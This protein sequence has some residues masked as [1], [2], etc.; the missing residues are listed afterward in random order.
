MNNTFN[1][2]NQAWLLIFLVFS[3]LHLTIVILNHAYFRTFAYDYGVYNFAFF[4]FAHL[5][6]SSCP[7]YHNLYTVSFMQD[8]FSLTLPML[9]PLYWLFGWLAGSY[10]LLIIQW[11]FITAGAFY[12]H[13]YIRLKSQN[14]WISLL[15]LVYYFVLY[16]RFSA[17]QAD[18]NLA[19]IGSALLPVFLYCFE[20]KKRIP[21]IVCFLF[22][23][24]NREDFSITL[25][26]LCLF[27]LIRNRRD[28]SQFRFALWLFLSSIAALLLIFNALIP[29]LETDTKKYSL[30]NYSILGESPGEAL[31]YVITH[32]VK[33]L[34]YL[35]INHSGDTVNN[36]VKTTFYL[37]FFLSGGILLFL[38]PVY[39]I[40]ILPLIAKK[41]FNDD[42]IRWSQDMYHSIEITC[43]LPLFV[44]SI[45]SEL[46]GQG[47]R[48]ALGLSTCLLTLGV[49]LYCILSATNSGLGNIKYNFVSPAFY[50]SPPNRQHLE[51]IISCIPAKAAVCATGAAVPHLAQRQK[52]YLF[53]KIADAEYV[54]VCSYGD[55]YPVS[56]AEL[57][58]AVNSLLRSGNWRME[59]AAGEAFLLKR[60]TR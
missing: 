46:K 40:C 24:F 33:A 47:L 39:L 36:S 57:E 3:A 58:G 8:H 56:R 54:M 17:Y 44:F 32:P 28:K 11:V 21:T 35:F 41:M 34:S 53:P 38:R 30:F 31:M 16:N 18:C 42:P 25:I 1:F 4:D 26:F 9:S 60:T 59:L 10:L 50:R 23:A 22:M 48:V 20:V 27:L 52:I 13:Q 49:S 7:V 12:T 6:V 51:A 19:I 43:L 15:A 55:C 29:L 45:I 14:P 5:R 37:I 2:R